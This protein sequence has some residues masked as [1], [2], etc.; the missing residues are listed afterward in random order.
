MEYPNEAQTSLSAL[1]HRAKGV[2]KSKGCMCRSVVSGV[3]AEIYNPSF[4][5]CHVEWLRMA[6]RSVSD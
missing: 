5:Y 2:Y 6:R 1:L 4:V 3:L